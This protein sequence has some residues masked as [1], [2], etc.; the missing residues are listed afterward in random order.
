MFVASIGMVVKY[1]LTWFGQEEIR[2]Y[3]CGNQPMV[4]I[5]YNLKDI[6]HY[7]TSKL[8]L[9]GILQCETKG[10]LEFIT[11]RQCTC[12]GIFAEVGI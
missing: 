12:V 11:Y 5:V 1:V 2:V 4:R 7:L 6:S 3:F 10:F 8:C 9:L